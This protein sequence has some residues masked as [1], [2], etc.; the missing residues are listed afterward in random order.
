MLTEYV[1]YFNIWRHS[2]FLR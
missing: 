2:Y 1:K